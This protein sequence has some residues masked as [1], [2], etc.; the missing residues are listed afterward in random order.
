MAMI[1]VTGACSTLVTLPGETQ[2]TSL[3]LASALLTNT[4][5]AG[6]ELAD[7]GPNFS[8]SY[9]WCRISS[10][11]DSAAQRLYERALRN[12]MSSAPSSTAF[13]IARLRCELNRR[14][15][16]IRARGPA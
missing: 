5:R 8:N 16:L 2:A 1:T 11:T 14:G 4:N 13:F 9:S 7:V 6:V 3:D 10:D 12:R 15:E